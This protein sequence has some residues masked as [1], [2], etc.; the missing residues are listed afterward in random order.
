MDNSWIKQILDRPI[1]YH[2]IFAKIC[3]SVNA[4]V[5]LS[6]AYYWEQ[7]V[8]SP[9]GFFYKTQ[10]E[11]E[12]ETC[13]SRKEQETCRKILKALGFWEEKLEGIPC[14]LY[15]RLDTDKLLEKIQAFQYVPTGQTVDSKG[16]DK[17]VP[18]GQTSMPLSD[19]QDAPKG[20]YS[21]TETTIQRV[22]AETTLKK[23]LPDRPSLG[24]NDLNSP[25]RCE[26]SHAPI[27]PPSVSAESQQQ[28]ATAVI[29]TASR[30]ET[31]PPTCA[32]EKTIGLSGNQCA[33]NYSPAPPVEVP[34]SDLSQNAPALP[35]AASVAAS[36]RVRVSASTPSKS[37][38]PVSH[39]IDSAY[40]SPAE[41]SERFS[42]G[43]ASLFSAEM[44]TV[45][46]STGFP[47]GKKGRKVAA[48]K[49]DSDSRAI[50]PAIVAIRD[51]TRKFPNKILWDGI[52]ETIGDSPDIPKLTDCYREALKRGCNGNAWYWVDWYRD[53]VP[54]MLHGKPVRKWKESKYE[55]FD[56][57]K[58]RRKGF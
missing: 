53:G 33:D 29:P 19:M 16:A 55:G 10:I 50:H 34:P 8:S 41:D 1:A 20:A 14:R 44:L 30:A 42:T 13:L 9:D 3:G 18:N 28:P 23:G 35:P 6:Q 56:F 32:R 36:G 51:L 48:K 26:V 37:E 27:L 40:C 15:Y 25:L 57:D 58:A 38:I 17:Y 45:E 31:N 7:R 43:E 46:I 52:I 11:W 54:E 12:E 24:R 47:Q 49:L 4:G 5:M 39:S 22:P 2:R 21:L